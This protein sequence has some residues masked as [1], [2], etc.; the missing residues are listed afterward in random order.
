MQKQ[1]YQDLVCVAP[2]Y[3]IFTVFTPLEGL[4]FFLEK[5]Y[6]N[7]CFL[8]LKYEQNELSYMKIRQQIKKFIFL[9]F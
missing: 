5:N 7:K 2:N 3:P 9:P 8:F 1:I 4:T 6:S